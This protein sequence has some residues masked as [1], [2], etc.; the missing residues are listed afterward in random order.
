MQRGAYRNNAYPI[1]EKK[2]ILKTNSK[3]YPIFNTTTKRYKYNYN[4]TKVDIVPTYGNTAL[5]VW[6]ILGIF[7]GK[8]FYSY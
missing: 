1:E 5:R 4:N 3:L 6:Y 7:P 8:S 2:K